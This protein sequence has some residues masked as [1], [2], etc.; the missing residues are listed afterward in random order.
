MVLSDGFNLDVSTHD[1]SR[2]VQLN[3]LDKLEGY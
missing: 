1:E 2:T 3:V